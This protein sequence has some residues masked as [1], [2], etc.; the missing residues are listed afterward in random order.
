MLASIS[1][2]ITGTALMQLWEDGW[3][4][5]DD[6]IND[7]LPFSVYNP[8]HP[9]QEITFRQLMT[10]TSSLRDNWS[11]MYYYEGDSPIPLGE[12]CEGYFTPGGEFYSAS[13]N[14]YTWAPGQSWSYCN[15]AIVLVGYLVEAITGIEFDRYCRDSIFTPLGLT[16]TSWFLEGMDTSNVAMPYSYDGGVYVPYGLF[17]YSD[18]PAGQLRTSALDLARHLMVY[19]NHGQWDSEQ[20]LD[21]ATVME[22][23]TPQVPEISSTMGLIWF[24]HYSQNRWHWRH[25]GGDFGV[26]TQASICPEGNYGVIVLTNGESSF[27]VDAIMAMLYEYAARDI[28]LTGGEF[29]DETGGDG[30]G[31]PEAGETVELVCTFANFLTETISDIDVTLTIDDASLQIISNS[32]QLNDIDLN[33]SVT[34]ADQ[35]FI[36]EIPADYLSR[37]CTFSLELVFDGGVRVDTLA[38]SSGIG[39]TSILLVDDDNNDNLEIYFGDSFDRALLPYDCRLS[40]PV[41]DLAGLVEYEVVI[42]MTGD[43][44]PDPLNL[45]EISLLEDY[46]DSGGNLFLTGQGIAAQLD[47]S[48]D[49]FLNTYLRCE[50]L[51][52]AMIPVLTAV[53]GSAIFDIADTIAIYGTGGAGNITRPDHIAAV[54]GGVEDFYYL[55][56]SQAGAI[57]YSGLY[58]LVFFGFGFEAIV[59]NNSRWTDRD[60]IL[61]DILD[62]FDYSE[63]AT[64]MNLTVSPGEADHL[65]DHTPEISWS[66]AGAPLPQEMYHVQ[67]SSDYDWTVAE[68][69]DYGPVSGSDTSVVY[70]GAALNDGETYYFRVRIDDGT[71]WSNWYYGQMRMNSRPTVPSGLSPDNMEE[72]SMTPPSLSHNNSEDNEGDN[73]TYSYELYDD[74]L[75][76]SLVSQASENPEGSGGTTVWVAPAALP[77]GEDYFWRVRAGDGFE[78]GQWSEL[79]SF[80]IPLFYVCGDANH[81]ESV[82]IGDAVY[83][84]NHVFNGGPPPEIS[85]AGDANADGQCDVGD[86]VYLINHVFKGGPEP[87]CP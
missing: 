53:P 35:P 50:Y 19:L 36:F 58:K 38:M 46:M 2:T 78:F 84:I 5:L 14:F 82:D 70:A 67:V 73:L 42:W 33:D 69:W 23:L 65:I 7:Y 11:V 25:G 32:A 12:Y 3:F 64:P 29:S 21:S 22:I 47:G 66:S 41:P 15:N 20:I 17:G 72:I 48:E 59:H 57:S 85:G 81:D 6:P 51:D 4:E 55:G 80:N 68:M 79:A 76:S 8:N 39:K 9:G 86:A 56:E 63:P 40:T 49:F 60:L 77:D 75:M 37:I 45:D 24:R 34:N 54:N 83:I 10:H 18:Y 30:D 26:R 31:L 74:S 13:A 87:Q 62:F 44:R 61:S 16:H 27:G 43:C 71:D 28:I 52:S 1:K